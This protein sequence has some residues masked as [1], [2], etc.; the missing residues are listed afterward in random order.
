M[1]KYKIK[2]IIEIFNAKNCVYLRNKPKILIFDCCRSSNGHNNISFTYDKEEDIN[3]IAHK[4]PNN[5]KMH[6]LIKNII[7]IQDLQ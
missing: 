6:G 2:D 5:P 7:L 3:N 1:T 4:G